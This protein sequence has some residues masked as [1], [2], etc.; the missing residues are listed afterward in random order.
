MLINVVSWDVKHR[1]PDSSASVLTNKYRTVC[2]VELSFL[3][4]YISYYFV[5]HLIIIYREQLRWFAAYVN[6]VK[7]DANAILTAKIALSSAWTTSIGTESNPYAGTFDGQ[8][9]AITGFN[10]TYDGGRQGLFGQTNGATIKNFSIAGT[11]TAN[12]DGGSD[13]GVGVIG[14]AESSTIQNVHS[15]LIVDATGTGLGSTHV[16]GVVGPLQR[17]NRVERCTFS[18]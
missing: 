9:H 12:G 6:K 4:C 14:W 17:C 11:I 15:S 1:A 16:G 7:A 18:D 5:I 2:D 8:N 3:I 10:L 13:A